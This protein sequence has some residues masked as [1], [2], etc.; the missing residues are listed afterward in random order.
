[1]HALVRFC[2]IAAQNT[3]TTAE[4]Y[5]DTLAALEVSSDEYSLNSLREGYA[6]C[7]I[8]LKLFEKIYAP[9][10]AGLPRPFSGDHK[11]Q[12]QKRTQL[13]RLYQRMT[14]D[15][16]AADSQSSGAGRCAARRDADPA[17]G[18]SQA[19][20]GESDSPGGGNR[21]GGARPSPGGI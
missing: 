2:H 20:A 8:F 4:I 11:L 16:N 19:A 21:G 9:L 6:I 17:M 12:Q 3:F 13:D 10:T 1:M 15:L 5:T 18:C 7:L 14:D